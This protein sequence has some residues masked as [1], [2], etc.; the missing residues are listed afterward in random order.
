MSN[1]PIKKYRVHFTGRLKGAIGAFS[2]YVRT[3]EATSEYNALIKLY[4]EFDSVNQPDVKEVK[5]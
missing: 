5:Q 1:K 3:I 4:D 2:T